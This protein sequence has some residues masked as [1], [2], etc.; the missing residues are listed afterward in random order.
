[1][2]ES[3][4]AERG[5]HVI[6]PNTDIVRQCAR[7]AS[8]RALVERAALVTADGM[9]IVWAS[10]LQGTPLPERVAGS[11]LI[12]LLSRA[13]AENGLSVFLLGGDPGTA[14][15][16]A[17]VLEE[18]SPGLVVA[19]TYFPEFGFER[20][21]EQ[22]EAVRVALKEARP[23]IVFV[24]LNFPKS[25]RLIEQMR[26]ALPGA[27]WMIVG[28]SFSFLSG[29]VRR[30]PVWMGRAGLEWVHRLGQEPRKLLRRYLLEGAPFAL[31]MLGRSA[32]RRD[33][34]DAE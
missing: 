34:D 27:W 23:D 6:T 11:N 14:E 15:A 22:L 26:D 20:N 16:A 31:R 5:G 29:A 24:G 21:P 7:D 3:C 2:I 10:Q 17:K 12:S 9:P 13:A 1:V 32:L 33:S 28:I 8:V 18:Q 30:A 25:A 19:G 4:K